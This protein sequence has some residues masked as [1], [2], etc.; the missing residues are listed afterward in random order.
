M[1]RIFVDL[2]LHVGAT[3]TLSDSAAH[4]LISV[5]RQRAGA[6]VTLF[7]GRGG[8]YAG[9]IDTQ[10]R[11]SATLSV[12]ELASRKQ[13]KSPRTARSWHAAVSLT[14]APIALTAPCLRSAI[15]AR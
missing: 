9:I 2:P 5:L 10:T 7:N 15:I 12:H 8:E 11:R 13:S 1:T 14:P 4:H 3:I 6:A